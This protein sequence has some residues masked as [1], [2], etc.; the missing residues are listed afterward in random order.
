M[1]SSDKKTLPNIKVVAIGGG[2]INAVNHLIDCGMQDV[3]FIS[4]SS[5]SLDLKLSKAQ[6]QILMGENRPIGLGM[7]PVSTCREIAEASR[8]IFKKHLSGSDIVFVITCLGGNTGTGAVS[9]VASCAREVGA[10]TIAIVTIPFKVEGSKRRKIAEAGISELKKNV[11]ALITISDDYILH[12]LDKKTSVTN[13]FQAVADTIR[14]CVRCVAGIMT[15]PGIANVEFKDIT[16]PLPNGAKT[17]NADE[18]MMELPK[19]MPNSESD[20]GQETTDDLMPR[21]DGKEICC[22]LRNIRV[23]LARA[24]NIPF[25]SEPCSFTDVCAGTCAKCDQ[26]AAYLRD[27]LN[28]IPEQDR[29][30]PQHILKDWKKALCSAK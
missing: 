8:D 7:L 23:E 30:Y 10:R 25:E 9:V 27:E 19:W 4:V 1:L 28:K 13:A 14:R 5:H 29:K 21:A 17:D 26:E 3:E 22:Y 16:V 18:Q 20:K 11:D 2:G 15:I 24:N 12:F 6:T